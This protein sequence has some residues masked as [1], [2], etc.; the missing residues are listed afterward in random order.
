MLGARHV[1]G[2]EGRLVSGANV[3]MISSDGSR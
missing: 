2:R 1:Q 3:V